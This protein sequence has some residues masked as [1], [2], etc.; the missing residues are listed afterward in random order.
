MERLGLFCT[1]LICM[2][3]L[4]RPLFILVLSKWCWSHS[5]CL[6]Q[7]L[8]AFERALLKCRPSKEEHVGG[9]VFMLQDICPVWLWIQRKCVCIYLSVCGPHTV[10]TAEC[11]EILDTEQF[12]LFL[13]HAR[14]AQCVSKT[15]LITVCYLLF[16]ENMFSSDM[17][18]VQI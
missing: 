13:G 2:D 15:L 11:V 16:C 3:A 6:S 10:S 4:C 17:C 12:T 8:V 9:T 5:N 1:S 18:S 14:K 7:L